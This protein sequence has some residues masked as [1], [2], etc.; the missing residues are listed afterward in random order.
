MTKPCTS[1]QHCE[2]KAGIAGDYYCKK[3]R[4]ITSIARISNDG[5]TLP[6]GQ[7]IECFEE[8]EEK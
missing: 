5:L 4:V 3:K 2:K 8:N 6:K 1:C 7:A